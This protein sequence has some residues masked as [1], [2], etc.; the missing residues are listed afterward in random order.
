MFYQQTN[1]QSEPRIGGLE[2]L[3]RK[4]ARLR[5]PS[6]SSFASLG[7]AEIMREL[8]SNDN[9][10]AEGGPLGGND[11]HAHVNGVRGMCEEADRNKVD[12][13]FGVRANVLQA[14]PA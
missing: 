10:I 11:A 9:R 12:S 14:D 7:D 8:G 6:T 3:D 2:L 1:D 4:S 5:G 13:S